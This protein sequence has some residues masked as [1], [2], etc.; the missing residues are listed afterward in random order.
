MQQTFNCEINHYFWKNVNIVRIIL[1]IL[2]L[3]VKTMKYVD[4]NH[5][6]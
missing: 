1:H 3:Q 5:I 6:F 4:K 2:F